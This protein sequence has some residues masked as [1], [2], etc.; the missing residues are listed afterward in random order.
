[1][2]VGVQV[3]YNTTWM[4]NIHMGMDDSTLFTSQLG[5]GTNTIQLQHGGA[6]TSICCDPPP[7]I[8]VLSIQKAENIDGG[9]E[10][11]I[12]KANAEST[13]ALDGR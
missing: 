5:K 8:S 3:L 1:M 11:A 7:L 6:T 4:Y 12:C 13:R 10:R 9:V 2:Y